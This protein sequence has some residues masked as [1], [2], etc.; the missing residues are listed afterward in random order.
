MDMTNIY[1]VLQT[2]AMWSIGLL[3]ILFFLIVCIVYL[4]FQHQEE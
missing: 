1:I 2:L 3:P 4:L